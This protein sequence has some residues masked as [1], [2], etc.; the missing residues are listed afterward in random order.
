MSK[1]C[2]DPV[3]FSS[4]SFTR[5]LMTIGRGLIELSCESIL[6]TRFTTFDLIEFWVLIQMEYP[7][8]STNKLRIFIPFASTYLCEAEFS[9]VVVIKN[10]YRVGINVESEVRVTVSSLF[11]FFEKLR[12]SACWSVALISLRNLVGVGRR[13]KLASASWAEKDWEPLI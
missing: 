1:I 2:L 5:I 11:L 4:T 12:R 7:N 9:V 6:Q 8:L 3:P 13:G 10:K